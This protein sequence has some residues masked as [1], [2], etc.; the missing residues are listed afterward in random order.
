MSL[1]LSGIK[2]IDLSRLLPGPFASQILADYGAEVIKVEDLEAGDYLR[3]LPPQVEGKGV[4]FYPINRGKKS[5]RLDLKTEAGKGIFRRLTENADVLL[6]G[7]RPG[8]MDKLGLG[9]TN[10]KKIN[11]RLIYCAL[12]GYGYTGPYREAAGHD[13]NYLSYAGIAGLIGKDGHTP[14]IPGV[15]IADIGG[16]AMWAII[17]ILMALRARELTGEG[18]FC[19]VAMLDGAFAWTVFALG[20]TAVTGVAPE[21]GNELLSGGYACY[22]IYE[23]ADHRYISL[24]AVE[25]KFWHQFC[26]L[27][28]HE[29]YAPLHVDR[30]AQTWLKQEV[31][32]IIAERT[33]DEWCEYFAEYD[34]CFA[35]VLDYHEALNNEQLITRE[36]IVPGNYGGFETVAPGLPV[37]LSSTPG[38]VLDQVPRAGEHTVEILESLGYDSEHIEQLLADR[39]IARS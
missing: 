34:F 36:M 14:V 23:T 5:L 1:P 37:K 24:G 18:Q 22:N 30:D 26:Q 15:Q 21:R 39:I 10:L 28:G 4:M 6:E 33:R 17:A 8:V 27:I 9:Y 32:A 11:P 3:V 31:A 38:K 20:K 25:Y 19:D 29:E 7:F 35:P 2:V 16:G 13:I 12:T